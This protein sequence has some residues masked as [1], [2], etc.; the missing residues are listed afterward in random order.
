MMKELDDE[1]R[2]RTVQSFYTNF[3]RRKSLTRIT[4]GRKEKQHDLPKEDIEEHEAH[5]A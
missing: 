2:R 1:K 5:P 3:P 4:R